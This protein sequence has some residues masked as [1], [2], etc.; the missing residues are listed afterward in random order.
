MERQV[1]AVGECGLDYDRLHFCGKAEQVRGAGVGLR[2]PSVPVLR[3]GGGQSDR[4]DDI[5]SP[6]EQVANTWY[7]ESVQFYCDICYIYYWSFARVCFRGWMD[8]WV[9]GC[10]QS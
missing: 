10:M 1:V 9:D 6:C 7:E 8:G 5:A 3:W 2:A 4:C